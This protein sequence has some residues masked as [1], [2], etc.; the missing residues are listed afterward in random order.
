[1]DEKNLYSPDEN[2]ESMDSNNATNSVKWT[3]SEF[4]DEG[5]QFTWYLYFAVAIFAVCGLIYFMTKSIFSSV[6]IVVMGG[7]LVFMTARKPKER[8]YELSHE[9][10]RIDN[11][12][13]PYSNFKSYSVINDKG[14]THLV[15][16]SI[17]RISPSKI[18]YFEPDDMQT[19]I[20]I[21]SEY[22]PLEAPLDD[23]MDRFS[24]RF[25]L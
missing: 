7:S 1:M 15:L 19:I 2:L 24:K 10:I 22:L 13:Y 14:I 5:K 4:V 21:I 25:R 23:P 16:N 17:R 11:G 9:G 8:S 12:E 18:I 3:A 20:S 6:A